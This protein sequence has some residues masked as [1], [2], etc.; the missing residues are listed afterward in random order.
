[1]TGWRALATTLLVANLLAGGCRRPVGPAKGE[2]D[3]DKG[4]AKGH[5]KGHADEHD[6]DEQGA[7]SPASPGTLRV[8]PGMVRDLR[9]T[10]A[11]VENR[12]GGQGVTVLGELRPDQE[13]YAE[14]GSPVDG[15]VV[16][17]TASPGDLVKTG[18]PLVEIESATL[19]QA[20]ATAVAARAKAELARQVVERRRR[21][22]AENISAGRELDE[23]EAEAK[24]AEADLAAARTTLQA[25]GASSAAGPAD[26]RGGARLVL[27]APIAG[28]VLERKAA[29]G[30]RVDPEQTLFRIADLKALWLTVHAF[31]RDALGV[32]LGAPVRVTFPA[33]PGRTYAGKV[34]WV[35]SEVEVASRTIPVRVTVE[36]SEAVLRPG[37][38]ASAWLPVGGGGAS[39]IAV[40]IAALQRLDRDW[41][42][43]VPRKESNSFEIRKVGRG[44][45]LGGEVEIVS[46]LRAGETVV[47]DGAFLLKAEAEKARGMGEH[48]EH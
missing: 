27:R 6:Q 38:S 34:A 11:A 36:N 44:R 5:E 30:Q 43:F 16:S 31:E 37:M 1:V 19:G 29:R 3:D 26:S 35:G 33:L 39:V 21:L 42:V 41:V 4:Q 10:T 7:R 32:T 2:H 14:V 12:P 8:D 28:T 46:A 24:A 48:H 22:V 18:A 17:V 9:I 47:V 25:F 13:A 40:P 23:A 20:R 45:D 15:R